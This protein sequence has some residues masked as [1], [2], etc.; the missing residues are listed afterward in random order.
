MEKHGH[1]PAC[2]CTHPVS[3]KHTG[4]IAGAPIGA[5]IGRLVDR[6]PW[7]PVIGGLVGILAGEIA[8]R[9]ILPRC[10]TCGLALELIGA[11][12]G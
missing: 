1:C 2:K 8:D 10:P 4:K 3:V 7:A 12:V 6:S 9:T 11:A 5:A